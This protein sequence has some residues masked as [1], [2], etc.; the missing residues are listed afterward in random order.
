M[1][2]SEITRRFSFTERKLKSL[3]AEDKNVMY[4]DS[5][6]NGL[7]LIVS[8]S[9]TFTFQVYGKL[10]GRA[11][12]IKIG[13]YPTVSVDYARKEANLINAELAKGINRS[14]ARSKAG[15]NICTIL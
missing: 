8:K 11:L 14:E 9:G 5:Q 1:T 15:T 2:S 10:N 13:N 7:K 4:H 3:K 6:I 12:K